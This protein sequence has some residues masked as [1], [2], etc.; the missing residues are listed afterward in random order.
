MA[1]HV[2]RVG[3]FSCL[4]WLLSLALNGFRRLDAFFLRPHFRGSLGGLVDPKVQEVMVRTAPYRFCCDRSLGLQLIELRRSC[5]RSPTVWR[6]ES[7][8]DRL[9]V[10]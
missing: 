5:L 8:E 7:S 4:G 3:P 1:P 9:A 6:V 2:R 10:L